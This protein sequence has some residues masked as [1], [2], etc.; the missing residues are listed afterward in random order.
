[1]TSKPIPIKLGEQGR[2]VIP[3]PLQEAMGLKSGDELLARVEDGC[4]VFEPRAAIVARVRARFRDVTG[5]LAEELLVERRS[6]GEAELE[7]AYV[8]AAAEVDF[9]WDAALLDGLE[10]RREGI[11][12]GAAP[13]KVLQSR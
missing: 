3:A 13:V 10:D 2:L 11:A 8:E 6:L 7:Q 9:G 1:M 5:S 4:L 12:S